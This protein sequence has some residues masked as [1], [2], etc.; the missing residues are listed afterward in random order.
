MENQE[1]DTLSF[2]QLIKCVLEYYGTT[3]KNE[4]KN[5]LKEF[6]NEL[7]DAD[8][9]LEN[10]NTYTNSLNDFDLNNLFVE[11]PNDLEVEIKKTFISQLRQFQ[12]KE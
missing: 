4:Q 7:E 10:F 12:I 1:K 2:I 5:I 6:S 3:K 8:S 9:L 11:I